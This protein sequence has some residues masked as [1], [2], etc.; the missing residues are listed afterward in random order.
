MFVNPGDIKTLKLQPGDRVDIAHA[1]GK[2]QGLLKGFRLV[3]Y[4]IPVGNVAAYFPEAN[5]LVPL[6]S[7]D[8]RSKTPAS[9]SIPVTLKSA[10]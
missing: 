1:F 6:A 9:K 2:G 10:S 8:K 4:D 7:I 5:V 3:A